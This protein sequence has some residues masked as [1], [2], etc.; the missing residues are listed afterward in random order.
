MTRFLGGLICT[1][2]LRQTVLELGRLLKFFSFLQKLLQNEE[3]GA[4]CASFKV[5]AA[6]F[7]GETQ[8]AINKYKLFLLIG[9]CQIHDKPNNDTVCI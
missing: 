3:R 9:Y 5:S 4:Q 1:Q 2:D 8:I 6:R 7:F